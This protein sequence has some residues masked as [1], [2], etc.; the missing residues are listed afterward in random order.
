[1]RRRKEEAEAKWRKEADSRLEAIVKWKEEKEENEEEGER[2]EE[3]IE[4]DI[5]YLEDGMMQLESRMKTKLEQLAARWTHTRKME[6]SDGGG[7]TSENGDDN[8]DAEDDGDNDGDNDDDNGQDK[9]V[10][11]TAKRRKCPE[12]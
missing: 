3:K 7:E 11:T 5:Q 2:K 4:N 12:R 9:G 10:F 6:K 8:D 1:M